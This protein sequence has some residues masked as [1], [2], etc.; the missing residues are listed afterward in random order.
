MKLIKTFL[1]CFRD[2]PMFD[3]GNYKDCNL[4]IPPTPTVSLERIEDSYIDDCVAA[5]QPVAIY[6]DSNNLQGRIKLIKPYLILK[7]LPVVIF[8]REIIWI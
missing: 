5:A 3:V 1:D 4:L 7:Q 8:G 2:L 6:L